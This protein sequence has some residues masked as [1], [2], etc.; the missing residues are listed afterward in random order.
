VGGNV[1]SLD[2]DVFAVLKAEAEPFVDT[3]NS[4]LRR[5]LGLDREVRGIQTVSVVERAKPVLR[6]QTV[7]TSLPKGGRLASS[8]KQQTRRRA[9]TGTILGEEDYYAPLLNVLASH[10][11]SAPARDV[12]KAVGEAMTSSLTDVD[13]EALSSGAIRWENRLQF[14]RLKFVERGLMERN[15]PRGTWQL[16]DAGRREAASMKPE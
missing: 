4:V 10:G 9:R 5:L 1:V 15:S 6:Q 16:T 12:V 13:R 14:V 11:G 2:D 7:P 3:P 8:G